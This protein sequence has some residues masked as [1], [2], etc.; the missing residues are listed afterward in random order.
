MEEIHA[1]RDEAVQIDTSEFTLDSREGVIQALKDIAEHSK[2]KP[3]EKLRALGQIAEMKGFKIDRSY[4]D[5][6][7]LS[8]KELRELILDL[9]VPTLSAFGVK[10]A[11]KAL[12]LDAGTK[13]HSRR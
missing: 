1:V 10:A 11:K 9:V 4:K 5:I 6:R 7:R 3:M 8:H 12:L 2:A 13:T